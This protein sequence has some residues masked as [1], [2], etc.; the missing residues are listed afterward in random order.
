M[1]RWL[2]TRLPRTAAVRASYMGQLPVRRV[3]RPVA[4]GRTVVRWDLL[5]TAVDLR[6]RCA[7]VPPHAPAAPALGAALA[8]VVGGQHLQRMGS[9]VIEA[10]L[11]LVRCEEPQRRGTQWSLDQAVEERLDR[12]C[13]AL[14]WFER[15]YRDGVISTT[16]P[17]ANIGR[18]ADPEA[19]LA[20]VPEYAVLDLQVQVRL[21]ERALGALRESTTESECRAGPTFAGG[22]A[23][24]GADGDLLV[25]RSMLE[26]KSVS[27]PDF[28]T[29]TAIRQLAGYLLLDYSDE[30]GIDEV[31][32][33]MSRIGWLATWPVADFVR[34]LGC[35]ASLAQLRL[36]FAAAFA[37]ADKVQRDLIVAAQADTPERDAPARATPA[38]FRTSG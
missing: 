20:L 33:Y 14:A 3:Q 36:D 8:G 24:G 18:D 37:S 6:L 7:F 17:L 13:F 27:R 34:L 19:L 30:Y 4:A 2:R 12:L 10:F 26:I 21:A 5:G 11:G 32:F 15:V 38:A 25:G 31:G 22:K 16:S 29:D 28:L 1:S 35:Q 23:V 9:A